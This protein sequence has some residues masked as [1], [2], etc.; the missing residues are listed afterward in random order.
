MRLGKELLRL[1]STI[2]P[3]LPGPPQSHVPKHQIHEVLE[4]FQGRRFP[5][6]PWAACSNSWLQTGFEVQPHQCQV[7]RKNP[8]PGPAAPLSDP[9]Q[10]GLGLP[11]HLGT[12]VSCSPTPDQH[13]LFHRA[14]SQPLCPS[15]EHSWDCCDPKAGPSTWGHTQSMAPAYPDPSAEPSCPPA[16]QLSL[17]PSA[18]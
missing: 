4:H 6:P 8:F 18:N 9:S 10:D 16:D 15:L 3:T 2:N 17:V 14:A 5:P 7:K 11:A 13:L 1:S 12:A